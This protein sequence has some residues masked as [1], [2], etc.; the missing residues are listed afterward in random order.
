MV[1]DFVRRQ[2]EDNGTRRV[3]LVSHQE[4][5]A[6]GRKLGGRGFDQQELL[7]RDLVRAKTLLENTFRDVEVHCFVIPWR[8]NGLGP[9]FGPAESVE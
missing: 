2:L 5:A 7:E 3:Y 9:A 6:Y 1:L 8:E 4:C